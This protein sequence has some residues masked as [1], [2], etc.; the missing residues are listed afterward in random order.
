MLS[1]FSARQAAVDH[2]MQTGWLGAAG[3]PSDP[4]KMGFEGYMRALR[5]DE[6]VRAHWNSSCER[7]REVLERH[8]RLRDRV[9]RGGVRIE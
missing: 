5:E 1:H 4:E 6:M 7:H 9:R 2:H 8:G 3:E